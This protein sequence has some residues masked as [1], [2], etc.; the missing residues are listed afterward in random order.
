MNRYNKETLTAATNIKKSLELAVPGLKMLKDDFY[1]IGGSAMVLLGIDIGFTKD[2]DILTSHRDAE[3]LKQCWADWL[4]A[5]SV[6]SKS[7][8]FRSGYAR[9]L[10]PA[11]DVEALGEL[12][13]CKGGIWY[14][15]TVNEY[16]TVEVGGLNI[17][18]P[19]L[20]DMVRI[21]YLFGR[22]KDLSRIKL[23][24]N[25]PTEYAESH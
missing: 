5:D 25:R 14:P 12:E 19:T 7:T 17:R 8:L 23:I 21:L 11:M 20:N 10:F 22:D 24:E 1:I 6:L 18:I 4:D 16:T 9:F 3:T 2:I 13:I 15:V